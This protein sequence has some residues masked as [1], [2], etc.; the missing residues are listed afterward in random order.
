MDSRSDPRLNRDLASPDEPYALK[1]AKE[2][3]QRSDR[4]HDPRVAPLTPFV[5][6]LRLMS[7]KTVPDFDPHDGGV[8][9]RALFLLEAPGRQAVA[10]GFISRNNPDPTARNMCQLL[11]TV[12]IPRTATLL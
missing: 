9:A 8:E 3:R 6:S 4:L 5:R 12:G 11:A 1:D 10:T 7:R 2:R